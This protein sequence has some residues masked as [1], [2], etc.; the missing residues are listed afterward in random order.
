MNLKFCLKYRDSFISRF[1]LFQDASS[2]AFLCVS[3]AHRYHILLLMASFLAFISD[4][5][6]ITAT[7]K[8]VVLTAKALVCF[9]NSM[10]VSL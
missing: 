2:Q 9:C 1:Y 6:C 7:D 8:T 5:C 4:C 10:P 3:K